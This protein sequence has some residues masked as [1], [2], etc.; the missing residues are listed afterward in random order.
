MKRLLKL[1]RDPSDPSKRQYLVLWEGN[2]VNNPT[3]EPE[4]NIP[5]DL[6]REFL[7]SDGFIDQNGSLSNAELPVSPKKSAS[8][9]HRARYASVPEA[10]EGGP[11][12]LV[13]DGD[14][15]VIDA[16]KNEM[17]VNI[18]ETEMQNRKKSWKRPPPRATKGTLKKYAMTVQN[19][20]RGCITDGGEI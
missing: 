16:E 20:S 11:I 6:V 18:D 14:E 7:V 10:F 8:P 1:G 15:I 3:W 19:A 9:S 17:N 5:E 12:A 2:W 13:K 4:E